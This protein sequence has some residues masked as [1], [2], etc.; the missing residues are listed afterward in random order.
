[1]ISSGRNRSLSFNVQ[2]SSESVHTKG[3]REKDNQPEHLE[4]VKAGAKFILFI[5]SKNGEAN[6]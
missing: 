2:A 6:I 1:M 3:R 5:R 4:Q